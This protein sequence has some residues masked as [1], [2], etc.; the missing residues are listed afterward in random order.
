MMVIQIPSYIPIIAQFWQISKDIWFHVQLLLWHFIY[1]IF[2][3]N[4]FFFVTFIT[5][6]SCFSHHLFIQQ[7]FLENQENIKK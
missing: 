4:R 6:D 5:E 7:T 2:I 3:G 1:Y